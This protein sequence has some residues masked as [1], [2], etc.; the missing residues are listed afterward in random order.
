MSMQMN[1]PKG[2]ILNA[3]PM[4]V[5]VG[6]VAAA[7]WAGVQSTPRGNGPTLVLHPAL[8]NTPPESTRRALDLVKIPAIAET[9][10]PFLRLPSLSEKEQV[11]VPAALMKITEIHLTTIAE[12][13][14]GRYCLVNGK[15]FSEGKAGEGFTIKEINK[16]KVVFRTG[17]EEF[18]L[19]PGQQAAVQGEHLVPLEIVLPATSVGDSEEPKAL[20]PI[21]VP[22]ANGTD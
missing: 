19:K 10:D 1:N 9:A 6:A 18:S 5:C 11:Q 15:I 7:I 13:T 2:L 21:M 8:T 16:E 17:L 14:N 3:L 20:A 4:I 12:G 22:P